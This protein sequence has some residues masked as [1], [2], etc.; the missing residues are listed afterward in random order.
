MNIHT[1]NAIFSLLI[2]VFS[3]AKSNMEVIGVAALACGLISVGSMN[4]KVT[5]IIMQT[6]ME[7]SEQDLKDPF[8]KY[9]P[10]GRNT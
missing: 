3:D 1:N 6:I 8:A 2:P 5:E 7:K 9:L 10:L 4:G